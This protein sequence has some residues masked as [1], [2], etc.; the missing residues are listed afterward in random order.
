MTQYLMI[1]VVSDAD[2][3]DLSFVLVVLVLDKDIFD[4]RKVGLVYVLL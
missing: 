2:C 3:F 4:H 1:R